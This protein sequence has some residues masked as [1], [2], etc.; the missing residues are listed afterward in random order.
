MKYF[1]PAALIFC[2][3]TSNAQVADSSSFYLHKFAQN[4][5]KE[6]YKLTRNG[7]N[8]TYDI[9]FK[10]VDRGSPV[11]LKARLVTTTGFDPI[12]LFIRGNT[13]RFS[14]IN[15]SIRIGDR[16]VSIRVD[17]SVRNESKKG[18][19]FPVGGYSPGTVQ[20]IL[21]QYWKKHGE[22]K[23]IPMIPS[24]VVSISRQG[25]DTLSPVSMTA[26]LSVILDRYV[27]SGL[28]WGNEIIWTD[29]GGNLICLITND[30]EGD[31][32][33]MMSTAYEDLL[34]ELINRAA[35]YGMKL[36][37]GSMKMD[38]A[39][40]KK[41]AIVG[42]NI[43]DVVGVTTLHNTTIIIEDGMI[44]EVGL[45]N[46]I[47]IPTGATVIHAEGKFVI[48]A[49]GICIRILNRRSGGLHTLLPA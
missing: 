10:F 14:A 22:P 2:L 41:L 24:G 43:I 32:L 34:P 46:S 16:Q 23:E 1:F 35:T 38:V 30:A 36:F 12:S 3:N 44:K 42:A 11:P 47:K 40:N 21:L 37:T 18:L 13:S 45:D 48:P 8:L 25:R 5:G 15:D 28:V 33:E 27:L 26:K 17:D 4:I 19:A 49:Y 7:N 29:Q 31:K 6:T 9:D 39:K 20:M